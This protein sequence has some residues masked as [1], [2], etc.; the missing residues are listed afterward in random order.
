MKLEK[1]KRKLEE[2][3]PEALLQINNNM[4]Y[5]NGDLNEIY[6]NDENFF[7][8]YFHN[9]EEAKEAIEN[10]EIYQAKDKFVT[11]DMLG[12]IESN[13]NSFNLINID[14]LAKTFNSDRNC[15]FYVEKV[16]K[17][18]KLSF[19]A[20][21]GNSRM[22]GKKFCEIYPKGNFILRMANHWSCCCDGVIYDTW[23]CSEK[24]VYNV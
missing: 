2:L 16:L 11:F 10:S 20:I 4:V 18:E 22:N 21:A 9:E 14:L 1:L 23:D 5:Y 7:K 12:N 8:L 15:D 19:P 24:C 17:T 13:N 3:E 6:K